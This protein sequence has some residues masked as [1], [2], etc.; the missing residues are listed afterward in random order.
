MVV[1]VAAFGQ[2]GVV[3]GEVFVVVETL[4][5]VGELVGEMEMLWMGEE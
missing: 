5:G 4:L 3:G 2:L 1:G